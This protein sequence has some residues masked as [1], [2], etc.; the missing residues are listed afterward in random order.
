MKK[1]FVLL[2][3]VSICGLAKAQY[4]PITRPIFKTE[5]YYPNRGYQRPKVTH[6]RV[7]GTTKSGHTAPFRVEYMDGEIQSVEYYQSYNGWQPCYSFSPTNKVYVADDY[8]Q[9][10]DYKA[11]PTYDSAVYYF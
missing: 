5:D 8:E 11:Q 9:A 1:L 10:Y 3:L 7:T 6:Q 4:T 2:G